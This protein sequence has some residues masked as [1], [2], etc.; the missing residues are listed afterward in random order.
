MRPCPD[1]LP[2]RVRL[3]LNF[4]VTFDGGPNGT[5]VLPANLFNSI[6]RVTDNATG[7]PV[8]REAC[9]EGP[10][11]NLSVSGDLIFIPAG[12]SQQFTTTFDLRLFYPNAGDGEL[13]SQLRPCEL[14]AHPVAGTGRPQPY[15]R[16]RSAPRRR[17]SAASAFW[18]LL[19]RRPPALQPGEDGA[20]Q[21]LAAGQHG[22]LCL[23]VR[24]HLD[25][26]TAGQQRTTDREPDSRH[27]QQR[28]RERGS[29]RSQA[30]QYQY[31]MSTD[32]LAVGPWLLA[33]AHELDN[34]TRV[35]A[36]VVR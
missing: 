9:A 25:G 33:G 14:R 22:G 28:L 4:T 31:N 3:L 5:Y 11:V 32:T 36:I 12:S 13:H 1:R 29:V 7:L 16:A 35:I 8:T 18:L 20:G 2:P 17:W 15:G 10:P 24:L 26:A 30:N 34:T 6:C 21:V 19:S 27:A 23:D